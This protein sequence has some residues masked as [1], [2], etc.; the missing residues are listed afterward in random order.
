MESHSP[1]IL[2]A[3]LKTVQD[4][5]EPKLL[6]DIAKPTIKKKKF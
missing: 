4:N 5:A 1:P 2:Q 3:N 6:K